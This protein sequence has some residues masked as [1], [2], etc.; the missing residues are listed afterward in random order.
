MPRNAE[1]VRRRVARRV[2]WRLFLSGGPRLAR[3]PSFSEARLIGRAASLLL[4]SAAHRTR[5]L[6]PAPK[7]GSSDA[8][9]RLPP[10]RGLSLPPFTGEGGPQGRMGVVTWRLSLPPSAFGT[11]PR[12]TGEGNRCAPGDETSPPDA[13]ADALRRRADARE[14]GG[15]CPATT[16]RDGRRPARQRKRPLTRVDAECATARARQRRVATTHAQHRWVATAHARHRRVRDD[17]CPASAGARRRM[18]GIGGCATTRAR[19]RRV[20]D[21]ACPASAGARRPV[22]G[23][24]ADRRRDR[25][26]PA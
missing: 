26:I 25:Y 16:L 23:G 8:Q 4:R 14:S 12:G 10:T 24:E 2:P 9:R 18:P 21:E 19:P 13:Q 15:A 17:A 20:R 1:G 3:P 6:P 11:F 5:S 7:R 22:P